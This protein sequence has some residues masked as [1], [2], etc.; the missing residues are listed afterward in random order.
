MFFSG[1]EPIHGRQRQN[2]PLLSNRAAQYAGFRRPFR[3][4]WCSLSSGYVAAACLMDG[5]DVVL[6]D[7]NLERL[8]RWHFPC[9]VAAIAA[10][11]HGSAGA[12]VVA[13]CDGRG[14][15]VNAA[16]ENLLPLRRKAS[17]GIAASSRNVSA[18]ND[19]TA[20]DAQ[21]S[22]RNSSS[23][24]VSHMQPQIAQLA[25]LQ[26]PIVEDKDIPMN[27]VIGLT[28][29]ESTSPAAFIALLDGRLFVWSLA[30]L[31]DVVGCGPIQ[32][33]EVY[34][35][36]SACSITCLS[37]FPSSAQVRQVHSLDGESCDVN[38]LVGLDSGSVVVVTVPPSALLQHDSSLTW[39]GGDS[40]YHR[41]IDVMSPPHLRCDYGR[42]L[43]VR[44]TS[45]GRIVFCGEDDAVYCADLRRRLSRLRLGSHESYAAS[46]DVHG[47]HILSA[48]FDGKLLLWTLQSNFDQL[49]Q[50]DFVGDDGT[51]IASTEPGKT[52]WR[53]EWPQPRVIYVSS[54]ESQMGRCLLHR[55]E[56][57]DRVA[58]N[59]DIES[60]STVDSHRDCRS[61]E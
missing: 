61:S 33:L 3:P 38:V 34:R 6:L 24:D 32:P 15:V 58:S 17:S 55:I 51:L 14:L 16:E 21:L 37:A 45:L 13:L 60:A 4:A 11:S 53:V 40:R 35:A 43:D 23:S 2:T 59:E 18:D 54:C 42:V 28:L 19:E 26:A 52:Y 50:S 57:I 44:W 27:H 8:G 31:D 20:V 7:P 41:D 39:S 48:G 12:L 36:P 5:S 9:A 56:L 10:L 46:V 1:G 22:P 25:Y 47:E 29:S 49:K 30:Y